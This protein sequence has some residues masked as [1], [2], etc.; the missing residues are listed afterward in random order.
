MGGEGET[1]VKV[2]LDTSVVL[3]LLT[4]E[5]RPLAEAA[6]QAVVETRSAGGQAAVSDLVVSEAY[7]ALQ[8]H[9][10]VPKELALRQLRALFESGDLVAAGSAA[11]VLATPGLAT[12]KPGFMDRMIHAGYMHDLDE[13]LT[14]E[15]AAGKL[16]HTRVLG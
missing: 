15:K 7:F 11:Q 12:A 9:Y 4:G 6:W 1:P 14:F 13:M 5:P 16:P 10:A 2:G 8:H 3:R